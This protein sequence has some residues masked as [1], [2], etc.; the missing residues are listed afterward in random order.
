MVTAEHLNENDPKYP[1]L[2]AG[3]LGRHERNEAEANITSAVRDFLIQTG[4]AKSEEI[5]EENPP[6]D[7]SR[8]AVDLTALD[9]FVEVKRRIGTAGS[10]EP[11]PLYVA[12]LDDYLARSQEQGKVR[13]GILTDGKYWLLRWPNAGPVNTAPPYG[14]TLD[15]NDRW[16]PLYEWLRDNALEALE[17]KPSDR[18]SIS[19]H[20]GPNSPSYQ[21]DISA[22]TALYRQAQTY[23]TVQ[24]KRRLWHDLLRTAL[25][26]IAHSQ[27][28]MDDLFIRHTYLSAVI[29]M[30]VQASFGIDL[31]QLAA[32][33]PED[34]LYGRRFRNDTGLQGI[35]E[36]DFFTWPAEVGGRPLLQTLARRIAKFNWPEA[37]ADIGAILYETV[38]PANERRQLGEYYTPAWL[39]RTMVQELVT[40]PL[41]QRVLDPACGSGTFIAEAVAHFIKDALPEKEAPKLHPKE[42][43]DKLRDAVTGID[44]HPVAVHLARAAWTLAARPAIKAA[45]DSGFYASLSIPVYLGD[46]L[47]LRFRTGDLFAE[48]TITIQTQDDENT[49]LVFPVSLVERPENFDSMMGQIAEAIERGKN[50]DFVLDDHCLNDP[51]ER[52]TIQATISVMQQLHNQGRDH[53]WAYYTSNM[54]R[55]VILS[56]NKVDVLIGNPPW[57]NYR[58]TYDV[59]RT[60]LQNLSRTRYDIWAGGRYATHQDVAGL[61]FTRSVDLYLNDGGVIGFVM[62]HSALQTGQYTK[63]RSG[64]WRASN[65]G[66]SVQVDF[67]VKTAWD[68]EKLE[69]NDFFPV[70]ASVVFARKCLPDTQGKALPGTVQRWLGKAGAEDVRRESSGIT[71]TGTVGDSP[72]AGFS[73]QGATIVPRCLFFVNET[74]NTAIIQAGQTVTVNP[75][76]GGNDKKPW[77]DLDLTAISNQ[78]IEKSHLFDVH[79]GETIA[80]YVTLKPLSALL[81]LR[82]EDATI[83]ADESGIGGINLGGLEQRMRERWRIVSALRDANKQPSD[84]LN[85]LGRLDYHRELSE[86]LEWRQQPGERPIRIVYSKSGE[87]TAALVDESDIVL[88]HLLYW[89]TCKSMGEAN[90]LL[91]IINSVAL[92]EAVQ[93][94]MSKGQYGARDLHKHLW[95]LP[96]PE[97]DPKQKL[98]MVIAKAGERAAAGAAQKLAEVREARGEKFSVT[99]AR[100]ELRNWLRS[101]AEGKEVEA[102]VAA[103]LGQG[104]DYRGTI[105]IEPNKRFGKPCI[106]GIRMTVQDVME[107]LAGGETWADFLEDFDNLIESDLYACLSFAAA[108]QMD[109]DYSRLRYAVI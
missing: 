4:L 28:E 75:R 70:P 66:Q 46:A 40:D 8:R 58:N 62:P 36:S 72:Y 108:E 63:W 11:N 1:L 101:S 3:I 85:L 99:I 96:I 32:T 21:R 98:H 109:D 35:V 24:V 45:A 39:A 30:V 9:T 23:E 17:N 29:G 71:D 90:Y 83:P 97:F 13:M 2:A 76:R 78:T 82:Q 14:F 69:P 15:A 38:I 102:A 103:L 18:D 55:P 92:Y 42:I 88:D 51:A 105:T 20:F 107:Y 43:L 86:Q 41:N 64:R 77:K 50:P 10:G 80:P 67:E 47:Q 74:A 93:P 49:E 104:V 34:L 106:R 52:K 84:K 87:P 31:R 68:L 33:E 81:P 6:S 25:G 57:L 16:L 60:E 53:I 59:L 48:N 89:I 7:S 91:A 79:L 100:D 44:I 65:S 5:A 61:F 95:K 73:R 94:L 56:R 19:E 12:Q 54:V 37:P 22:L 26:E 27:V